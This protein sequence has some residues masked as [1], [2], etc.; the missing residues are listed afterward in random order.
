MAISASVQSNLAIPPGE[1][2]EEVIEDLGMTKD[3]LARRMSRPASKLSAIFRG[4]KAITPDTALQLEKVVGVPAHIWT[5]LETEY[6][7]TLARQ[8][9]AKAEQRLRE[10]AGL[11][12]KFQY[13]ELFKLG[14]VEKQTRPADKVLS[15]QRFF[16]VTSL[17]NVM[18]LRRY[19]AAFRRSIVGSR[20]PSPEATAAWLRIGEI[21]AQKMDC[22][23][24]DEE[25]LTTQLEHLR[26]LTTRQPDDFQ[27][28]LLTTLANTGVAL[29]ICPHLPKTYVHGATFCLGREKAVL[30]M[31][32]RGKWADVFWFSLF[33]ELGHILLHDR[34]TVFLECDVS[35]RTVDKQEAEAN[36]FAEDALIPGEEYRLFTAKGQFYPDDIRR[37]A[38]IIDIHPGIVVGRLQNDGL[39]DRAWHNR[40]RERHEWKTEQ[41]DTG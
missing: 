6:R 38:R 18:E 37:F 36:R 41:G 7:L 15:L 31:T 20:K 21:G 27:D 19:Q 9:E 30:M 40:L 25:R 14:I 22:A 26:K 2:L 8:Q 1:Y 4:D 29:V 32:M 3:E 33:H 10:E 23:P 24:F 17:K 12:T 11:V 35:D 34:R 5:G 28:D 16:G 39:L 13:A